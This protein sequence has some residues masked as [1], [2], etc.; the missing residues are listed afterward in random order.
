MTPKKVFLVAAFNIIRPFIEFFNLQDNSMYVLPDNGLKIE[1]FT[2]SLFT[3]SITQPDPSL[4]QFHTK[5]LEKIYQANI[6]KN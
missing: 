1:I 4:I 6:Y 2:Y 3:D 5:F